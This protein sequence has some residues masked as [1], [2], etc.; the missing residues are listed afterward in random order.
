MILQH[1]YDTVKVNVRRREYAEDKSA[2]AAGRPLKVRVIKGSGNQKH[3]LHI[4][5]RAYES[6]YNE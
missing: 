5:L 2:R 3:L 4:V 1:L 6:L